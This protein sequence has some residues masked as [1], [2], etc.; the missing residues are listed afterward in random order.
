M[1]LNCE[2]SCYFKRDLWLGG[3]KEFGARDASEGAVG[4]LGGGEDTTRLGWW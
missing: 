4:Q 1:S 3:I 2:E